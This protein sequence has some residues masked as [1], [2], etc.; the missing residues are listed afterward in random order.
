LYAALN[1]SRRAVLL[2][3]SIFIMALVRPHIAGIM[4]IALA[5]SLVLERRLPLGQRLFLGSAALAA[6]AAMVPFALTYAGLGDASG[7]DDIMSYVEQR[8][9]LNTQGGSSVDIASMSLPLQL[10]S[11]LFRPLPYE[12][13]SIFGLAASL[14]NLVLIL[15]VV[16]G[17]FQII[18]H[19][20]HKLA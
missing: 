1:M 17:G 5:G 2:A 20:R 3:A 9:S 4:V 6:T 11:Y 12:A 10:F 8:Q 13:G 7:A 18:K 16:A 14:D 15:L 19:R